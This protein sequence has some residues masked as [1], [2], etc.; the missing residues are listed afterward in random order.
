MA[1]STAAAADQPLVQLVPL[2]R[3]VESPTNPRK[4]FT[5][6]EDLAEDLKKR[7]VLQPVLLRPAAGDG[8]G[9]NMLE[10][11]FGARRFRAAKLAGLEAI[12][13]MVR[14]LTAVEALEIQ[15]V[16]NSARQDVHAMEEAEGFERLREL[17]PGGQLSVEE[18]AAKIGKSPSYVYG[19][20]KLLAL[21]KEGRKAFYDGLLTPTSALLV[22]RVA[23]QEV[24]RKILKQAAEWYGNDETWSAGNVSTV[25]QRFLL[26]LAEAPFSRD[27]AELVPAAGA[28]KLCPKRSG[29]Q[30]QLFA[31]V[32]HDGDLCTDPSCFA[33]KSDAAWAR[34]RAD[35]KEKGLKVLDGKAGEK[36]CGYGGE[37]VK[38][39]DSNYQDP[40]GRTWKQLIGK[41]AKDQVVLARDEK[42]KV[43]ELVPKAATKKQLKESGHK[44]KAPTSSGPTSSKQSKAEAVKERQAREL[45]EA[46]DRRVAE[47]VVARMET[48]DL[49]PLWRL[50]AALAVERAD[51]AMERRWPSDNGC[52]DS[53]AI[54]KALAAFTPE[55][56]RALVLEVALESAIYDTGYLAG[57]AK[58]A[59]TEVLA[60]AKVDPKTVRAQVKAEL[61]AKAKAEPAA[62]APAKKG[63][64]RKAKG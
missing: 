27:D 1:K 64:A 32:R 14:D 8:M 11:V 61:E 15:V 26:R 21:C 51:L 30:P 10:L 41:A 16:E 12:P 7:G 45:D 3:I 49:A 23:D 46:T 36:A 40:K 18:I 6:I 5:E 39:A 25:V 28:C 4:T 48:G 57:D 34:H 13:A 38:L 37:Y 47:L 29:A 42:G 52:V 62:S 63:K 59:R 2:P 44:L 20:M 19:R 31:D 50:A 33:A 60:W 56:A 24:Q 35:A 22:A 58:K 53:K 54:D 17:T 43:H 9:H 55:Q